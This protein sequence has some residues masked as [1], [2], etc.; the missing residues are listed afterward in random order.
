MLINT[1]ESPEDIKVVRDVTDVFLHEEF[2]HD[3]ETSI[4]HIA[5]IKV[6]LIFKYENQLFYILVDMKYMC[7]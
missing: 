4:N 3:H 1:V 5:I 6:G 2:D 7:I